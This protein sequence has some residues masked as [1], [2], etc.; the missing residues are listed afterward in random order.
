VTRCRRVSI[1]SFAVLVAACALAVLFAG[2]ASAA[3]TKVLL[4][5]RNE[6]GAGPPAVAGEPAH[7]SNFVAGASNLC[8]V[9]D[10]G[11][12][13]GKN[14]SATVKVSGGNDALPLVCFNLEGG[15]AATGTITIKSVSLSKT[16]AV[17]L[18]GRLELQA[19]EC[20]FRATKLTGT[21][22]FG[23]EEQF[24]DFLSGPAKLVKGRSA[25]TCPPG[26]EF[27]D[28]IG[29]ADAAGFNYLVSLTS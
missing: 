14:P 27:S 16:G 24:T 9:T 25:K 2:P 4:T 22:N 20:R 19:G 8:G 29:V 12:T 11:A 23:P 17:T 6:E 13:V 15:A 5:T 18:H 26:E 1:L 3:G 10:E 21:Q 28:T 7:I